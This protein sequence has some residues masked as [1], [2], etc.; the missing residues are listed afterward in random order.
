MVGHMHSLKGQMGGLSGNHP[1]CPLFKPLR[2]DFGPPSY[3]C[4]LYNKKYNNKGKKEVITIF[5]S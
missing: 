1:L 5:C 3:R 4:T 2:M